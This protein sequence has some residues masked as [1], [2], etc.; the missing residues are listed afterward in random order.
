MKKNI[1]IS[2]IACVTLILL[3]LF[4]M[5]NGFSLSR[6]N[7]FKMEELFQQD[8][9]YLLKV[10]KYLADCDYSD[11]YIHESMEKNEL[12]HNGQMI[13]I[14]NEEVADAI[15][16]LQAR[17]YSVIGKKGNTV[18]F[19]RWSNLDCGRGIAYSTN[20]KEIR[21]PFL[22]RTEPLSDQCWFYYEEN[23][24]EW[25]LKNM[26]N[27]IPNYILG[28]WRLKSLEIRAN[29][30]NANSHNGEGD[31]Q[32]DIT[33]EFN[34]DGTFV[35]TIYNAA[36]ECSCDQGKYHLSYNNTIWIEFEDGTHKTIRYIPEY[37]EMVYPSYSD[38]GEPVD[39]FYLKAT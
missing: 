3:I 8:K 14:D 37:Q 33:I 27:G 10:T 20:G 6:V 21:L 34:A 9:E 26:T 1:V 5:A 16:K 31:V 12:S 19:Q 4:L 7:Y 24:N 18:Y 25:E 36:G 2:V 32:T 13:T 35:R 11:I 22:T 38:T 17:K 28:T 23:F 29:G 39:E 15:C 30:D